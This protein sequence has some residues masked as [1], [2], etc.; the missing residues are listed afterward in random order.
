MSSQVN[1]QAPYFLPP[2]SK[3]DLSKIDPNDTQGYHKDQAK[4]EEQA[5][6]DRLFSLQ[7]KLY[8]SRKHALLVVMQA[9]DT[10]GKDGAIKQVFS[11]VNPQ[12][13]QVYAFKG[14]TSLELSHDFLWRVHQQTPAKG[15]IGIFNRSHYE[16]VL[17]ARVDKLV[18]K[19]VWQ[20]R[21]DHI[22]NFERMLYDNG[23]RILKFYLHISR[24][25]QKERLT[26][27]LNDP[28]K[29]WKFS[30]SDLPV[31]AKWDDYMEAYQDALT[32][33][34]TEYAPWVVV[35][36]NKKWYR[37]LL[38]TRVIVETLE[39]MGL[40]YPA[41]EAGLDKIVVPD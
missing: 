7:D 29:H 32:H 4:A 17:I 13:V 16:D 10:G 18:P 6:E 34:N 38:I 33:C 1:P 19:Q 40:A 8:A 28:E 27:R 25:E 26:N 36:A 24:E 41:P 15:F 20:A 31:R 9:M 21:Y 35:P 14:P 2:L 23:T 11:G 22:N 30:S 3:I 39:S 5:Y 12:G 37:D